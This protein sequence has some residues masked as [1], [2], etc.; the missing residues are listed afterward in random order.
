MNHRT[1]ESRNEYVRKRNLVNTMRHIAKSECWEKL[2]KEEDANG[3]LKKKLL[4]S[5]ACSY[6]KGEE[7]AAIT[8][9][10]E[11]GNE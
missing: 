1:A 6:R 5:L 4:F 3:N 2:G 7:N 10:D 9:N 8:V 11:D